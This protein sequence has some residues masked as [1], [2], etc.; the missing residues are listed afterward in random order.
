M[1]S[2]EAWLKKFGLNDTETAVYLCILQHPHIRTADIQ[3]QTGLVRTTIYYSLAELKTK[4]LISE[5][6]QNNIRTYHANDPSVLRTSIY[7]AITT[8][9]HLLDELDLLGD[10]FARITQPSQDDSRVARYEGD[11]AIKQAIDLA[12]RCESKRWYILASHD[13]YLSHTSKQYQRYYL[14]EREHRG[15]IAHTLWEPH[16]SMKT[17][18][19]RSIVYRQPRELP[20]EFAGS[21]SGI[22]ILYDDVTLHIGPHSSQSA[23]AI[24]D[25]STT[26]IMRLLF[27]SLWRQAPPAKAR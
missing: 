25:Q 5:N 8:Q 11:T 10:S 1:N 17:P 27:M 6:S 14:D 4:G 7:R 2:I 18:T 22:I 16:G 26:H 12:L 15:I 3:K 9:E 20:T 24:Y 19:T 23:H 13:N 21:F